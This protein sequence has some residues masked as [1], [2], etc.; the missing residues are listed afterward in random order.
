[1]DA[2]ATLA[3]TS[4][5]VDEVAHHAYGLPNKLRSLLITADGRVTAGILLSRFGEAAETESRLQYLVDQG[6]LE[7]ARA[8]DSALLKQ[9]ETHYTRLVGPVA[10]VLVRSAAKETTDLDELYAKL[11]E[12]LDPAD[13]PEFMATRPSLQTTSTSRRHDRVKAEARPGHD[14]RR[15]WDPALLEQVGTHYARFVGPIAK[16][17]V[18]RAQEQASDI[19][20]LYATLADTLETDERLRFLTT[21]PD[22]LAPRRVLRRYHAPA[23]AEGPHSWVFSPL[24]RLFPGRKQ[25]GR[26]ART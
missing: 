16:V 13:G 20:E 1:M 9:I 2:N 15:H 23:R 17:L 19:E 10:R 3:K 4:K 22:L 25:R 7:Q 6:F 5:G 18:R 8:W 11:A 14:E 24:S 26:R 21:R 12:K